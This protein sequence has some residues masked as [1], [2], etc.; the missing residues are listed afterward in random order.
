M[1]DFEMD[2]KLVN[3]RTTRWSDLDNYEK[4]NSENLKAY[5]FDCPCYKDK[6]PPLNSVINWRKRWFEGDRKPPILF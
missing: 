5:Q 4:W 3:L 6:G 2:G 1:N